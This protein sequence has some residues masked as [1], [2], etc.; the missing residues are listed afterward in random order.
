[1]VVAS[2]APRAALAGSVVKG[3]GVD[4]GFD[5]A[6]D[7]VLGERRGAERHPRHSLKGAFQGLHQAAHLGVAGDDHRSVDAAGGHGAVTAQVETR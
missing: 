4:P 3:A 7:L 1:M 6:V 5:D 2:P